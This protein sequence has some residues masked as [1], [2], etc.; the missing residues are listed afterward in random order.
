[1]AWLTQHHHLRPDRGRHLGV[2]G[3][4]Q[5]PLHV[6]HEGGDGQHGRH[7]QGDPRRRRGPGD[8][9]IFRF[10]STFRDY[11]LFSV[12][13][14]EPEIEPGHDD[15]EH[16]RGV[17]LEQIVAERSLWSN[18]ISSDAEADCGGAHQSRGPGPAAT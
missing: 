1:M 2:G 5:L 15:D 16:G 7:A 17:D 13:P 10:T 11:C 4:G 3:V 9:N 14:V 18:P 6:A 12:L 8:G